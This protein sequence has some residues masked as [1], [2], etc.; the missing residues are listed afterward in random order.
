VIVF[1]GGGL[2]SGGNRTGL[3]TGFGGLAAY[4]EQGSL[5]AL[6][7][8]RVAWVSY[9][10]LEGVDDPS[11][12][13]QVMRAHASH[14]PRTTKP[15]YHFGLSLHAGEELSAERWDLV[16]DRVL[17]RMGLDGH[18]AV[19]IAHQDT[20]KQ[21][22]HVI[23]NRVGEDG[24]AWGLR[25][26][27]TKAREAIRG[28]EI[29][30][31]L[32]RTG[33]RD[34]PVPALTP[35]AYQ[36]A[37]RT[38]RQPLA[39]RVREQAAA[40]FTEATGWRELEERLAARGFR[41]EPAS[42]GS[43][44]LVT[45]GFRSA[46]LSHVDRALSGPKL[47]SRFGE[48]LRE[49]RQAHPEPPTVAVPGWTPAQLPGESLDE[50]AAALVE[51]LTATRATFTAADLHRG[52]FHQSESV[53]LVRQ[54]LASDQVIDLGRDASGAVR[55]TTREY[56]DAE[57]RLLT[58]AGGL[59]ARHELRLDTAAVE[60]ALDRAA[61]ALSTEQRDAVLHATTADDLAQIV[62]RA[63][64]GKTTA[65]RTIAAAYEEAGY[66]V[67]GAALAGKAAEVLE[68][69]TGVRSR[70]LASLELRWS[71]GTERLGPRSV[72]LV[73]EAGMVDVRRLGRVLAYAEERGAKVVLLGDPDQLKAIGAGD[74]FRGLLEQHPS[75]HIDTIRRQH[76][77]WQR[78]ASEE[79]A[80]G[81][82]AAALDSYEGAGR[83][84]WTDT[85]AA[86]QTE[87]LAIYARDRREH[88]D[89]AQLILAYRNLDVAQLNDAVRAERKAAGE[90]A[91]GIEV[92]GA[93]FARGDRIVFLRNDNQG[94]EVLNLDAAAATGVRNGTLGTVVSAETNRLSV[95]LDEGRTVAFDPARYGSV[96]HG[97]AV[98]IHKSQGATVD[99][100][101]VLADPLMNRNAAYV[102]LTRHRDGVHLFADR[103]TF[104]NREQLDKALSRSGQKDLASDYASAEL[105]RA[106]ARYQE[107]AAQ[108]A[109]ATLEERPLREALASLSSL[110]DERLRVVEARRS[111]GRAAGQVYADP[112]KALQGLLRD[113]A[114]PERLRQGDARIY[115]DLRGRAGLV[116]PRP[117]RAAAL[118][119]VASLTGRLDAYRRS[120]ER[121]HAARHAVRVA[122]GAP[123]LEHRS[124]A[125]AGA[126]GLPHRAPS[127]RPS[128]LPRPAQIQ[129]ELARVTAA[130]RTYQEASRGAQNAIET[131]IRGMGRVSL[132]TAL[133][134]LPPKVAIPVGIAVRAV[135][136]VLDRGIDLGLGR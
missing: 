68:T 72:L 91:A 20:D 76:E 90:L 8:D 87:L 118:R 46:S 5:D 9:R 86:A 15:V 83:L 126:R 81:R 70:T 58:A 85:R 41:L 18:Q 10:N 117:D 50:R 44:V 47:A 31:G 14:Y 54:A 21:H 65:A 131:A 52:A 40:A 36:H 33:P 42:R 71:E 104:A 37:L 30:Y 123:R 109:R 105:R 97:Y 124:Q 107:I 16:V 60:R 136:R 135:T 56:L 25:D 108:T 38:G 69:E 45:D 11:R 49:H 63:G 120:V 133:L 24:R 98:T 64:A 80:A 134:L 12:A 78:A 22:V 74:A 2:S 100:V 17:H 3:G 28:I 122:F 32:T 19:V 39:D 116:R 95:R 84:H 94:R 53:A 112:G 82:V 1:K 43:G 51:R 35:G 57:A 119:G 103:E 61:P 130:L 55:Y 6:N 93:E 89:G 125:R 77:P 99:R 96:A 106:V 101:Y 7:P 4:L 26:D 121:L 111:V 128:R 66:E 132:N 127:A 79:L 34:L 27:K 67:R 75:A 88:P 48:T 110:R 62:G 102:A 29:D 113:P 59:A 92:G 13:A 73:D 129:R 115:G 114:A 23:V